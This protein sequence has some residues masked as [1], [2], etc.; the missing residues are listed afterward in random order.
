MNIAVR[1]CTRSGN[2]E[3][4]AKAIAEVAGV[5]AE[6]ISKPLEED[7]DLLF[8]G[9]S[10]YGMD[11]DKRIYAFFD[12]NPKKIGKIASFGTAASPASSVGAIEKL[13]TAHG[14]PMAETSFRCYGSFGMIHRDRPNEEDLKDARAF[15]G[16]VLADTNA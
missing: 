15:A 5:P 14:I 6:D 1:Y 9:A 16:K 13:A 4:V 3:K 10:L 2:T 12:E 11:V 7:V 8:L